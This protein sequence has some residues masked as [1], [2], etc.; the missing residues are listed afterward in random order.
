MIRSHAARLLALSLLAGPLAC[1]TAPATQAGRDDLQEASAQALAQLRAEDPGLDQ[2]FLKGSYA[3]AVFPHVGKGGYVVGGSYGRGVVYR[4]GAAIGYADISKAS[5]GLQVGA[6][7]FMEVL[8]F[9]G[10]GD[11]ERFT[12]GRLALSADVSAVILKS[13]A[14]ESARYSD[15]VVAFVKPIGGA[16]LEASIGGQQF[17]YQPR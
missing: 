12:A 16:M 3:Y 17:T 8:V 10:P 15:G 6:E 13:G 2:R 5:I 1:A 7:T 11:F 9:E 14:A 4:G